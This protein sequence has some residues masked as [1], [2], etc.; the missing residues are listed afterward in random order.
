METLQNLNQA[1]HYIEEHLDEDIDYQ[2][3][4]QI[5]CYSEHH[6]K[7]MFSFIAGVSL[8]EY[9]KRR[10]LTKAAFELR[11]H[12]VKVIDV[13]VKYGYQS[14]DSFSRAFQKM[15]GITPQKAKDGDYFLKA[16]PKLT[17]QINIRG[18]V[19]MNY[20]IVERETF[21]VIGYK[22]EKVASDNFY[23]K[24][25]DTLKEDEYEKLEALAMSDFPGLLHIMKDTEE[26]E[27]MTK[28]YL[29]GVASKLEKEHLATSQIPKQ[30]WS[31]FSV[32]DDTTEALLSTWE[33]VYTEWF[34]ASDY[35]L[36]DAPEFVRSAPNAQGKQEIWIPVKKK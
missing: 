30:T 29:I 34:P 11:E 1:I 35:E 25:W 22:E 3:V 23:P 33:R 15:H 26:D 12:N 32:E 18:A 13:A 19:E 14:A 36:A 21:Q 4:A 7:R 28:S 27:G 5:S 20:K 17:F 6:F 24:L 8:S 31:V 2:K 16:F 9:V 10:R